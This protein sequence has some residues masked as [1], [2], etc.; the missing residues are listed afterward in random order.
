MDFSYTGR[1]SQ[2]EEQCKLSLQRPSPSPLQKQ[3]DFADVVGALPQEILK[4]GHEV[5]VYLPL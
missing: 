5:S 2:G 3:A 1:G 4:L